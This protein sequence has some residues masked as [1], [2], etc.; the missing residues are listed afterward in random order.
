MFPPHIFDSNLAAGH[1]GQ[2]YPAT[3]FNHIG[4]NG[5]STTLQAFYPVD[6]NEIRANT[7]YISPHSIEHT[8]KLLYIRLT[9][10]VVDGGSTFS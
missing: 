1:S 10:S 2:T 4:Q 6:S 7:L 3:Y 8:A 5:M 9:S